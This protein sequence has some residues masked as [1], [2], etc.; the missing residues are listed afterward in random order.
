MWEDEDMPMVIPATWK[1]DYQPKFK[2]IAYP[3]KR[4]GGFDNVKSRLEEYANEVKHIRK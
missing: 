2:S 1:P 4:Y 3:S